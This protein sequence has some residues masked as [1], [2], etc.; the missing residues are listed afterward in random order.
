M[1]AIPQPTMGTV[2]AIY[3]LHA[4]RAASE[5]PRSYLGWS[6]IGAECDRALWYS[7]RQ[8]G[9][10][11]IEGRMARLF[12]TGHLE[13]A[14][15][16]RELRAIGM[17]V[18]DR[19]VSGNQFAVSSH[20]GHFRGH[21][22]AVVTG[23]IEAPVTP[24]LVDVKSIKAKK[25]DELIKKG[26]AA[27]YP[28]YWA[29]A[30]GYMGKLELDRAAFIFSC[31]DDD[32][33]H[34][35]RI[36]YDPSVFEK[37]EARASRIIQSATPPQRISDDPS[38]FECRFCDFHDVCHGD[39]IA[40]VN[41]RT[42]AHATPIVGEGDAGLWRC[43]RGQSAIQKPT[44]AHQCH[45]FIPILLERL[46]SPADSDGDS[47]TYARADGTKFTN[48][49]APAFLSTEIAIAPDA[50]SDPGVQA[51]KAAFTTARVIA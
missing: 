47:V 33:M 42:C 10:K 49:C 41:C 31:K 39:R 9:R 14:R 48:G 44:V 35:E 12:E 13:E 19:D 30:H 21:I 37:Y 11:V 22:D 40:A 38:W 43:E 29:Q 17:D 2:Q 25:F 34:V 15:V 23:L 32:R 28:K 26:M 1:A 16:L 7:F 51:I 6:E 20:G 8:V 50:V 24:H 36:V 5:G 45:R 18:W 27:L 4:Q 3:G 46:G